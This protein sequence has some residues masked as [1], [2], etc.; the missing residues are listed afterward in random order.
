VVSCKLRDRTIHNSPFTGALTTAS[1]EVV[2][3]SP[4]VVILSGA[5]NERSRRIA[6]P[7]RAAL[8]RVLIAPLQGARYLLLLPRALPRGCT[9]LG[10][11]GLP[12]AGSWFG[13]GFMPPR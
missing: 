9:D 7:L 5:R 6:R 10:P 3:R 11:S 1:P 13:A 12:D 4:V 8:V 2:S